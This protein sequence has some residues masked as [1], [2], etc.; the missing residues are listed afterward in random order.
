MD[1]SQILRGRPYGGV[2]IIFPDSLGSS[3]IFIDSKSDR[4]CALHIHSIQLYLFCI[5][6]PCDLNDHL[7]IGKYESVLSEI[8]L[9]CIKHNAEYVCIGGDFNTQFSNDIHYI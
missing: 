1:S 6:M 8:S 2:A 5:Y 9:L 4:L 3:A 7:S